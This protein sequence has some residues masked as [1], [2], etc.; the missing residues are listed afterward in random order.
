MILMHAS[1]ENKG[2]QPSLTN[3]LYRPAKNS[4]LKKSASAL[5]SPDK[6]WRADQ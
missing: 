1:I 4:L 6:R 5:V 3:T 2:K